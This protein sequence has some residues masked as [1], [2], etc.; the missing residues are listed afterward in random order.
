MFHSS[1]IWYPYK[2][3]VKGKQY[4]M[5]DNGGKKSANFHFEGSMGSL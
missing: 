3:N 4:Q 1:K 5:Q 2:S